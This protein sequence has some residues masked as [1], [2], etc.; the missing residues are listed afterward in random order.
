MND[1]PT[2]FYVDYL[3]YKICLN[4][5]TEKR[6]T[7]DIKKMLEIIDKI[8]I[9]ISLMDYEFKLKMIIC[10]IYNSIIS[11][12]DH[13]GAI[14]MCS[15]ENLLN[16]LENIIFKVLD[17]DECDEFRL[18]FKKIVGFYVSIFDTEDA[19]NSYCNKNIKKMLLG[20]TSFHN[21]KF[22]YLKKLSGLKNLRSEFLSFIFIEVDNLVEKLAV[23]FLTKM[24]DK[25]TS[26]IISEVYK[27]Q[28]SLI[29]GKKYKKKRLNFDS[30]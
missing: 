26:D 9:D 23:P 24:V 25:K 21:M 30:E 2:I 20:L 28:D 27:R 3:I 6:N 11:N 14:F 13:E 7:D 19:F 10:M 12:F 29:S 1:I 15:R 16:V 4:F 17:F 8:Q 22:S 5:K 18:F